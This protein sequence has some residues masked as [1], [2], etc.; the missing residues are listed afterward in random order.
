MNLEAN[1][2]VRWHGNVLP[3]MITPASIV[4]N[5]LRC[6][7]DQTYQRTRSFLWRVYYPNK[8]LDGPRPFLIGDL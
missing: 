8:V 1:K 2:T 6:S 5:T 7:H 4:P 3:S